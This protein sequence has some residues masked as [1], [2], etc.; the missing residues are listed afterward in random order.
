[1]AFAGAGFGFAS[2]AS[3]IPQVKARLD[4]DPSQLGLLLLSLAAGSVISLPLAGPI[5][6]RFGSRRAVM[7]TGGLGGL[8]LIVVAFGYRVGVAPVV[9]GLCCWGMASGTWDVAMNVQ[10]AVVERLLGRSVMPRFHAG[11]S[12]GTVVAALGGAAMV[13]LGVSVTVHLAIVGVIVAAAVPAMAR[14]FV[15]DSAGAVPPTRQATGAGGP[16]EREP[17]RA[18]DSLGAWR[19]PRTLLVGVFV[20][21]FAFAEG[22][23]NDWI[24]LA[25][26]ARHH[27]AA[28]LGTLVF[29]VFLGAMTSARWFGPAA[30]DRYGRVPVVRVLAGLAVTGLVLFVFAPG[31]VLA[32]VGALLWGTGTS[33]GFPVGMSAGADE[34]ALAAPRV[35]VIATIGYC[36]FLGGP[37]LIGF[38]GQQSSVPHALVAVVVVM[39]IAGAVA[40]SVR[41]PRAAA[42]AARAAGIEQTSN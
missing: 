14:D 29:A 9:A 31:M 30:L 27:V 42:A 38:V 41:P 8:G 37:P 5:V 35:G 32:F 18:R 6:A 1:M 20:L 4:L 11:F 21:G 16:G 22:T 25:T 7:A 26:I 28:A 24:S 39:V 33:L 10:G 36:A 19:E 34:P 17:A 3:R 13:A 12:M 2:W 23:G 15:P 40:G